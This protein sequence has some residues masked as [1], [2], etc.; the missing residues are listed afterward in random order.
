MT[1]RLQEIMVWRS[2]EPLRFVRIIIQVL[3]FRTVYLVTIK[4]VLKAECSGWVK[5]HL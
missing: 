4:A 3:M 5:K 1:V 2:Q